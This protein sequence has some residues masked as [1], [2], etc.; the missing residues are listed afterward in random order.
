MR[1]TSSARGRSSTPRSAQHGLEGIISKRRESALSAGP[2][3]RL[4]QG[5]VRAIA[6]I[7]VIGGF[8]P[9]AGSQASVSVCHA[10]SATT[11]ST[12]CAYAGGRHR[13]QRSGGW[14][15]CES[16][17]GSSS[18]PSRP[19]SI[20]RAARAS[21]RGVHWVKPTLVAQV[22]FGEWTRDGHLRHPAYLGLRGDKAARDVR[23]ERPVPLKQVLQAKSRGQI[24][25][26]VSFKRGATR[27]R[28]FRRACVT[29]PEKVLWPDD[30]I[31]KRSWRATTRASPIGFCRTWWTGR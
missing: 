16:D 12:S 23:R 29:H 8:T 11:K 6:K 15:I 30:G 4:G 3:H 5:E 31:T 22:T 17:L 20:W 1:V 10:R 28:T 2:Q 19:S 27:C 25:D 24:R 21:A 7:F 26:Q 14:K 9:P 18:N 13:L